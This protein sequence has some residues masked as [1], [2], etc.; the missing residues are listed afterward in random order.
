MNRLQAIL[1]VFLLG[2]MPAAADSLLSIPLPTND[3]VVDPF[4]GVIYAS[5]P[6]R[7]DGF[8]NS[9][10]AIDPETNALG[11]PLY[12]GSEPGKLALSDDGRYLCVRQ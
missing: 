4:R 3:M 11:A 6:G 7:A 12:V 8:G 10:V 5:V 2:V 1:W 9:I